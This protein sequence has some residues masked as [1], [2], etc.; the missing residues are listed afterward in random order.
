MNDFVDMSAGTFGVGGAAYDLRET[1]VA[2]AVELYEMRLGR[3]MNAAERAAVD[4]QCAV[5]D[6]KETLHTLWLAALSPRER[7]MKGIRP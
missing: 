3:P 7:R 4:H 5:I 1:E 6:R 2:A